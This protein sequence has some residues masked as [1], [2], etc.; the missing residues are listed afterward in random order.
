MKKIF[1]Y[2]VTALFLI[3]FVNSVEV[4]LFEKFDT[5][6]LYNKIVVPIYSS[7]EHLFKAAYCDEKNLSCYDNQYDYIPYVS[8][9]SYKNTSN[10]IGISYKSKLTS[11]TKIDYGTYS[12]Y[13]GHVYKWL[14][15][16]GNRNWE[17]FPI[18]DYELKKG[19]VIEVF[20]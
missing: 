3:L 19:V 13:E 20:P 1:L 9:Y 2:I 7:S 18:Q 6:L 10:L 4:G 17:E 5:K 11:I 12:I 8:G 16:V 14:V 15:P